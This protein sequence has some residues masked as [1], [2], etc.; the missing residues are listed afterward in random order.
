MPIHLSELKTH[1][2]TRPTAFARNPR[3]AGSVYAALAGMALWPVAQAVGAGD[4]AAAITALAGTAAGVGA[5]LIANQVQ[6]WK[7]ESDAGRSL[8][9]AATES[10]QVRAALDAVLSELDVVR[11]A[12]AALAEA[13]RAWFAETLRAEL[14]RLGGSPRLEAQLAA[15]DQRGQVVHGPQTNIAGDVHG[16]ILSGTFQGPVVVGG[17]VAGLEALDLAPS[18]EASRLHRILRTRLN[19]EEFRTLCFDLGVNYDNLGGEGLSGKA[20]Q[21]VLLL[22]KRDAL[23]LLIE[24]LRQERPD[25]GV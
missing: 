5:N 24:W 15:F 13:D 12:Q 21:L 23:P 6:S 18:P 10:A 8:A 25:I 20:R 16:P 2:R 19:L 7:D 11:E 9:Q 22:Q 17:G 3:V 1:L 4:F 14:A